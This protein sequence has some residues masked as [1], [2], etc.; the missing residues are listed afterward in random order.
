MCSRNATWV[1]CARSLLVTFHIIE[2]G[3]WKDYYAI[4][5]TNNFIGWKFFIIPLSSFI[6]M[7]NPSWV[8]IDYEEIGFTDRTST[9][10]LD[11]INLGIFENPDTIV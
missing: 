2:T 9:Y 1:D 3:T 7:G 5:I 10:Y 6:T 8:K 4:S 11:Q